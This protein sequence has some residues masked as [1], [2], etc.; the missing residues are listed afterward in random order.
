MK[1]VA[2]LLWKNA[3]TDRTQSD[4]ERVLELLKKGWQSFTH[5]EKETWQNGLK[6]ALN[7]AD[8]ERIQN[9][10]QLLSDVLE[11]DLVV[12]DIP[13]IP[14]ADFYNTLAA[15]VEAIRGAY[16][17]HADTPPT[18]PAPLNTFQKWN[19]IEKILLDVYE[20]LMNNFSYYCGGEIY[21]GDTS[22]LLL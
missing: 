22:G 16:C 8:L 20:I 2:I 3:V 5:E 19:D 17:I 4:V 11:L 1:R 15:N 7:R 6:G 18:P 9:N 14:M 21:A 10:V 12:E 13:E